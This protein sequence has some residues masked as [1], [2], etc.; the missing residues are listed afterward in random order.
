MINSDVSLRRSQL[1]V[2][3]L[4]L[5]LGFNFGTWASRIP[6]LKTQLGLSAAEVGIL[7][8][9]SGLGA[10]FSFPVTATLLHKLG[11]RKMCILAGL[12]LPCVL[13]GLALA[14]T[15]PLAIVVM[16]LEGVTV[17][18]LNVAMNSQGVEVELAGKQ[19]IMSRLHAVFSLGGLLAALFASALTTSTDS[20][21]IHFVAG[22]AVLW[23]GVL[24]AIPGLLHEQIKEGGASNGKRFV[25][26]TGV[27]LWLGMIALCGTI[28][29]GSMSDW[30]ALYLKDVVGASA[31]LA[32]L[33]IACVSGTMLIAR[34]FGDGW[35]TRFGAERM[36]TVGGVLAGGGLALALL[37]GGL[38]PALLG[39]ALVGL[40]VAAVSP[41]VYAA[42][43]KHGAVALAAVTTMGSIGAL[44]GPPVIGFIAHASNLAWGMAVIALAAALIS[45][46]TKKVNWD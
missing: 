36:L 37:L 18:C 41:C 32:P 20:V 11:S 7:L 19:A 29:E 14:P 1:A 8:L 33:G 42:A 26:P 39:F 38:V 3:S 35:R 12:T 13:I 21:L 43:A 40:G 23:A 15:F 10:V 6:A 17:A 28:V 24:Y 22:A 5:V 4:F 2:A 25:I 30:S 27:A 46:C 31:Q 34:W 9:A 45:V 44:M 16:A